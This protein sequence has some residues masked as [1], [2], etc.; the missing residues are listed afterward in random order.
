MSDEWLVDLVDETAMEGLGRR[1]A[2]WLRPGLVIALRGPLGAGKTTL[3]RGVLRG[4]G[5]RGIVRSPT[6]AL[7]ETYELAACRFC[8][9]DLYRLAD[10][11]EL[12]TIGL[13]DFL[14]EAAVLFVEWPDRGRGFLPP[15]DLE[16]TID[17]LEAGRRVGLS[18]SGDVGQT[19]LAALSASGV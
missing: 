2:G 17:Y 15:A 9:C 6:Y 16:I 4:L 10:P 19:I 11:E 3:V 12:E 8:H 7:V 18:A 13:R 14:D 1:L 5:H